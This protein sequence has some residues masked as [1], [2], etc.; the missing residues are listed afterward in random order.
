MTSSASGRE[1]APAPI[2]AAAWLM[3]TGVVAG[4]GSA[5]ISVVGGL[6][7]IDEFNRRAPGTGAAPDLISETVSGM[8]VGFLGGAVLALAFSTAIGLLIVP[9]RR[10]IRAARTATWILVGISAC[11]GGLGLLTTFQRHPPNLYQLQ[12]GT[13]PTEQRLNQVLADSVPG[14]SA[15]GS[16][17]LSLV[18]VLA[19]TAVVVLL[20]L[21]ASHEFFRHRPL[22][23]TP[24]DEAAR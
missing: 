5:V 12:Y 7:L 8:R 9:V 13:N 2:S 1:P 10:G 11:C 20:A 18:Q 6:A 23:V 24:G 19:F 15:A 4:V 21:P 17:V 3:L 22:D 16:I 14:W